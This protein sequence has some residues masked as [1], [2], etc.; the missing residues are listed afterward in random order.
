MSITHMTL[1]GKGGVGKTFVASI[2]AQYINSPLSGKETLKV[3]DTD[4][5]NATLSQYSA[6]DVEHLQIQEKESSRISERAFDTLMEQ[7]LTNPKQDFVID[8]GASSF[9]PLSNYLIENSAIEMMIDA[10]REVW[11]HPVI[12]GGLGLSDT[13][14]G[15][16]QLA[17]QM[18]KEVKIVV[19]K[20]PYFGAI[21]KDGKT[22]EQMAVYKN[23]KDRF[24][25]IVDI[26]QQSTDTFGEDLKEMLQR[27]MTFD[28][29]AASETFQIMSRQRLK[30]TKGMIFERVAAA[31]G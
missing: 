8:N 16:D 3:I 27:K 14:S 4:P 24:H 29:A 20:N 18:P 21:E 26:P 15:L 1:Q 12:T 22:F 30:I 10:G 31:L 19:W 13:L 9:V 28:Q 2:L 23:N 5:V 25:A 7:M 17:K 6:F 11:I